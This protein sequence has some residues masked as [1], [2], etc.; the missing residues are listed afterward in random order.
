[1]GMSIKEKINYFH[2]CVHHCVKFFNMEDC[3]VMIQESD[4][5]QV[6]GRCMYWTIEQMPV[7][8]PRIYNIQYNKDWVK[9]AKKEEIR[10]TAM[11]ETLE[12]W[13]SRLREYGRN[14]TIIISDREIDSEVHKVICFFENKFMDAVF[15]EFK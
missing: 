9:T 5:P 4:D 15:D 13:L 10:K 7:T 6:R 12:A 2:K 11:H 14:K 1:M 8:E 3:E